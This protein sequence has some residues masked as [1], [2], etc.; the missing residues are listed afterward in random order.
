MWVSFLDVSQLMLISRVEVMLW[1]DSED[2][3]SLQSAGKNSKT[4]L[5]SFNSLTKKLEKYCFL[6]TNLRFL[7]FK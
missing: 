5:G 1:G 3:F 4:P 6:Q 7:F 2:K